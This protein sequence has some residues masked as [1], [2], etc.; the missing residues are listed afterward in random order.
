[1]Y[2]KDKIFHHKL[3]NFVNFLFFKLFKAI[4]SLILVYKILI[5]NFMSILDLNNLILQ[6]NNDLKIITFHSIYLNQLH[7]QNMFP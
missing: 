7:I 4:F 3:C 1:M 5:Y 6:I 2:F